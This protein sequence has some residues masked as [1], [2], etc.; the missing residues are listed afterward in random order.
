MNTR[1]QKQHILKN[2][3]ATKLEKENKEAAKRVE[4]ENKE[5]AKRV[6]KENKEAAKRVEKENKE[7]SKRV[8]K[9]NKDAVCDET[10]Q[11]FTKNEIELYKRQH[12]KCKFTNP[13]NEYLWSKSQQKKCS[14]CFIE[15]KLCDFNGN[16]SGT[17]AFNKDGYRLR[18]PEC[19]E[20]TKKSNRG[21]A[22][23]KKKARELGITSVAPEGTLCSIC[24]KP[25]SSGNR[26]VFDHCHV[27][28]IFRGYCC[29]SCN[30][31]IGVFGDNVDGLLR[32]INYLLKNEKCTIIQEENGQLVKK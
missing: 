20:C 9:E 10:E 8:E 25:A 26:M 21:K 30:R 12:S 32:V 11:V 3:E 1:Y 23:T 18:R 6:E 17:D 22:E 19:K 4:K 7:A 2:E 27:N 24:N 28:N 16:T 5:A 14:K 29:N 13:T 15:K 31:S